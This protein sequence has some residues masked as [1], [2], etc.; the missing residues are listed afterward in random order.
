MC[1]P[2]LR[3]AGA[4]SHWEL[5]KLL[6]KGV[7]LTSNGSRKRENSLS[8]QLL[9]MRDIFEAAHLP[10]VHVTI[11][12]TTRDDSSRVYV[13]RA[14]KCVRRSPSPL[15]THS[16]QH[17]SGRPHRAQQQQPQREPGGVEHTHLEQQLLLQSEVAV[18]DAVQHQLALLAATQQPSLL[19]PGV[20]TAPG[21]AREVSLLSGLATSVSALCAS[22]PATVAA[23]AEEY[24]DVI[25]SQR[26]SAIPPPETTSSTS[27]QESWARA[28]PNHLAHQE[29]LEGRN[30]EGVAYGEGEED[31]GSE[32][33]S[34]GDETT[35]VYVWSDFLGTYI[36]SFECDEDE[37]IAACMPNSDGDAESGH[38]EGAGESRREGKAPAVDTPGRLRV[39]LHRQTPRAT[40]APPPA[41]PAGEMDPRGV[42]SAPPPDQGSIR[43]AERRA[44]ELKLTNLSSHIYNIPPTPSPGAAACRGRPRAAEEA[45]ES[46]QLHQDG[47]PEGHF[48]GVSFRT[49]RQ[50]I[51]PRAQVNKLQQQL[52]SDATAAAHSPSVAVSS[53]I[54][55]DVAVRAQAFMALP[56]ERRDEISRQQARGGAMLEWEEEAQAALLAEQQ[57]SSGPTRSY[58]EGAC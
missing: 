51:P 23:L 2:K 26:R 7:R 16:A 10:A 15:P 57:K 11:F 20:H 55:P 31:S 9:T 37:M 1:K 19:N 43:A 5:V 22:N 53:S 13:I 3:E 41:R 52:A 27:S 50:A 8:P 47:V 4:R 44:E 39:L 24:P 54:F 40:T 29:E 12:I 25:M 35:G 32:E 36:P 45:L 17:T 33:D 42:H 18:D 58:V 56:R 48:A 34:G 14:R 28:V 30:P 6:R 49:A 46:Q 21:T 38:H